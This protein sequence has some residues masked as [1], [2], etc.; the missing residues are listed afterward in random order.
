MPSKGAP[1][2]KNKKGKKRKQTSINRLEEEQR[3]E[4]AWADDM[5]QLKHEEEAADAYY[6]PVNMTEADL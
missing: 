3:S 4:D 6:D 2:G 5:V 1:K